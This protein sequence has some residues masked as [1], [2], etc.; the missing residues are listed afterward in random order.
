MIVTTRL[1]IIESKES[2]KLLRS[3]ETITR[4]LRRRVVAENYIRVRRVAAIGGILI[5]SMKRSS[6]TDDDDDDD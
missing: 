5:E 4:I 3:I 2:Q 1:F 6:N